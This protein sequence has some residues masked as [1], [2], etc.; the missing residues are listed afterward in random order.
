MSSY[1]YYEFQ[2]VD[3]PLTQTEQAELR[4]LSTRAQISSTRFQ[5]VYHWGSFKGQ[6]LALMERY[7]DAFVYV[8]NWQTNW[9]M[10]RLPRRL[11]DPAAARRY[12]VEGALEVHARG[13]QVILEFS[14]E[15][16]G[17]SWI[18]DEEAEG[19]M[20]A[21]LPVRAELLAGDA[22]AL[23]L[24]WLAGARAELLE[25]DEL[26]P[27]VPAGLGHLSAS[28]TALARFLRLDDDLI[29]IAAA[30]SPVLPKPPS[31]AELARG[32]Q[33]LPGADKD[34]L[35]AR[36]AIGSP[37]QAR[38]ELLRRL[39]PAA[40]PDQDRRAAARPV[41]ELL[42]AADTRAEERRRQEAARQ[43]AEQA[44]LAREQAAARARYLDSLVG[45]EEQLWR[46][47]EALIETKRPNDYDRAVQLLVD[48]HDLGQRQQQPEPFAARLGP[49][50]ERY[51]RRPSLLE[52]LDRAGLKA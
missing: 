12:E 28:L 43:A 36:L 16:E 49:L 3:R 4:S 21:L 48:L 8:A 20:P 9:L 51:A 5:N 30:R 1:E 17:E 40:A 19:W 23:Y 6:P 29:E 41:A 2:A 52:R 35:L 26:E 25:D 38:A 50:R 33:A 32:I 39:Q 22:R 14:S 44:R 37:A 27:P 45:R 46:Q 31:P 34:T 18:E 24:G 13:D 11:L 15:D 42:A 7:F 47:A 10:L